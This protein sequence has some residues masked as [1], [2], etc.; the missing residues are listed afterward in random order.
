MRFWSRGSKARARTS[1]AEIGDGEIPDLSETGAVVQHTIMRGELPALVVIRD[2]EDFWLVGDDVN[3]PNVEGACA[4]F[5]L[6]HVANRWDPRGC[7][8]TGPGT[9]SRP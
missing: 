7:W 6:A 9:T 3:D 8:R 4:L 1:P 5:H 2:A